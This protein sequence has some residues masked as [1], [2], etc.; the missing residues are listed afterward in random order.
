M[1]EPRLELKTDL[2][3][4][5]GPYRLA[6]VKEPEA[7]A[8]ATLLTLSMERLDGIEKVALQCRIERA[9]APSIEPSELLAKLVPWIERDFEMTRENALKSIRSERKL[10]LLSFDASN[11]GPF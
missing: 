3:T 11:R 7:L 6:L 9:L 8:D 5:R 2:K 1:S 4:G 10:M